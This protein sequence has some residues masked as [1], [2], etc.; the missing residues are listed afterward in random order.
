MKQLAKRIARRLLTIAEGFFLEANGWKKVGNDA[1]KPPASY[2]F[3]HSHTR[4]HGHAVNSQKY[5]DR[6]S[7]RLRDIKE[8]LDETTA[9]ESKVE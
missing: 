6:E 1:W 5:F 3:R 8:Y 4:S 7:Q 9:K 2:G